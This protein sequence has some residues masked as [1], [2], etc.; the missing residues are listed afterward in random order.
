VIQKYGGSSLATLEQLGM[1]ADRVAA[2]RR[3]IDFVVVVV[4]ARGRTTDTLLALG[5]RVCPSPPAR[6]VDALLSTGEATSAALLSLALSARGVG[7]RALS[8][9]QAGIRT[10]ACHGRARIVDVDAGA[11]VDTLRCGEVPVV[12]GF[13][14]VTSTGAITTI[15]RG[16][17]DTTAVALAA[18][19]GAGFCDIL[20]DVRGVHSADPRCDAAAPLLPHLSYEQIIALCANGATVVHRDAV[21]LARRQDIAVRVGAWWSD[22]FGSVV[23]GHHNSHSHRSSDGDGQV[24][25]AAPRRSAVM[26]TAHEDHEAS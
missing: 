3:R 5:S 7:A 15:G 14:G 4:S 9:S 22:S 2:L 25:Q 21:E 11:V 26:L 24:G 20:T 1:V 16:G 13:Q 18:A 6:E 10:C 17:S 19:L 23:A 12:A 8:G